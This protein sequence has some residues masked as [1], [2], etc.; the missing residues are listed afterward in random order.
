MNKKQRRELKQKAREALGRPAQNV[1]YFY[2]ID[3]YFGM[4]SNFSRHKITVNG[5]IYDTSEHYYQS[6]KYRGVNE[7]R[8]KKVI[9]TWKPADAAVL[10]RDEN[11][12]IREDWDDVKDMVMMTALRAKFMQRDWQTYVLARTGKMELLED[13]TNDTY[14]GIGTNGDGQNKLGRMLMQIR[15]ELAL[16]GVTELTAESLL[17]A[18]K[19][20]QKETEEKEFA[21]CFLKGATRRK[22]IADKNYKNPVEKLEDLK[23]NPTKYVTPLYPPYHYTAPAAK[24]GGYSNMGKLYEAHA[25]NK[26]L[27]APKGDY[28]AGTVTAAPVLTGKTLKEASLAEQQTAF[29]TAFG[30][31]KKNGEGFQ[32]VEN[33]TWQ[34][35]TELDG[36]VK[37][38]DRLLVEVR[39]GD[40][41]WVGE[42]YDED[43]AEYVQDHRI[44]TTGRDGSIVYGDYKD[45][46]E[47]DDF[48]EM[49]IPGEGETFEIDGFYQH[50]FMTMSAE[51]LELYCFEGNEKGKVNICLYEKGNPDCLD[52]FYPKHFLSQNPQ[53]AEQLVIQYG[54][55]SEWIYETMMDNLYRK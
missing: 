47:E 50:T 32:G 22:E 33:E 11:F 40:E 53:Y 5:E 30:S 52:E 2:S 44:P 16:D 7:E 45:Y 20:G 27:P 43:A 4:F 38:L 48:D 3:G 41:T 29:Q 31:I 37:E 25:A 15:H 9:A 21:R 18:P 42:V 54:Q 34:T 23:K 51:G 36:L 49:P 12:P 19:V 6:E 14:W 35:Q 24:N 39:D 17:V 13:T 10:S 1:L 55:Y 8:R 46:P 26:A 28:V